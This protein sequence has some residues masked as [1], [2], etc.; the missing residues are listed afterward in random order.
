[1]PSWRRGLEVTAARVSGTPRWEPRSIYLSKY[2]V[3]LQ[4]RNSEN[5]VR[6]QSFGCCQD[7]EA[8]IHPPLQRSKHSRH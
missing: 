2:V 8:T 3:R 5:K 7:R 4:T 1:M 6:L